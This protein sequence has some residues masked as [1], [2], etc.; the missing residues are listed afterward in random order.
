MFAHE[1]KVVA[2][3][4]AAI[5]NE[6]HAFEPEALLKVVEHFRDRLG[7]APIAVKDMVSDRP[8]IDHNEAD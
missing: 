8:S 6:H 5:A 2:R 3:H 1:S 7:V 4:H